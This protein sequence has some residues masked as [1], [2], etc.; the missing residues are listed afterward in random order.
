MFTIIFFFDAHSCYGAIKESP[1]L[2][3]AVSIAICLFYLYAT[4]FMCTRILNVQK[5][6]EYIL[7][8]IVCDFNNV[9]LT[10]TIYSAVN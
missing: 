7:V 6:D 3:I 5:F 4:Q 9:W 1:T 10:F 8:M 2:L